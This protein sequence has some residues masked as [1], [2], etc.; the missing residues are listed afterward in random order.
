MLN[1]WFPTEVRWLPDT[2]A[3]NPEASPV[4][5]SLSL[6]GSL[7]RLWK[8]KKQNLKYKN[9]SVWKILLKGVF[10]LPFFNKNPT[11]TTC[12]NEC[13]RRVP[14][15]HHSLPARRRSEM[16]AALLFPHWQRALSH[17][18]RTSLQRSNICIHLAL[19][20]PLFSCAFLSFT[21]LLLCP[22]SSRWWRGRDAPSPPPSHIHIHPPGPP[23]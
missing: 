4:R 5:S 15:V 18:R 6:N 13:L 8:N 22:F 19:R 3:A 20:F 11:E 17:S 9:K 1:F 21:R 23:F 7:Q 16:S 10:C 12:S 14:L 2:R